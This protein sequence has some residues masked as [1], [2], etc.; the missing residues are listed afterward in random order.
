MAIWED[1][2]E[3]TQ[4]AMPIQ[5][6]LLTE[7]LIKLSFQMRQAEWPAVQRTALLFQKMSIGLW[8]QTLLISDQQMDQQCSFQI[9]QEF[10]FSVPLLHL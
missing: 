9:Q 3:Q 5:T 4:N 6:N 1:R 2:P 7:A 8:E 10:L